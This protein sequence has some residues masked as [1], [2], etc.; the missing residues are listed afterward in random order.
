HYFVDICGRPLTAVDVEK[1]H[2]VVLAA[3]RWQY[4]VSG[5][6]Q[7]R[8]VKALGSLVTSEHGARIG[9]AL[10]PILG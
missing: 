8:F 9:T 10:A 2:A 5:V 3:Y 4:I 1:L 7:P 6:R